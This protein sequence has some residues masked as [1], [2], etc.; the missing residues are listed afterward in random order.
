[1]SEEDEDY[2][3][4]DGSE[5]GGDPSRRR[6]RRRRR[7]RGR[8]PEG[9][10]GGGELFLEDG[11]EVSQPAAAPPPRRERGERPERGGRARGGHE[12]ASVTTPA[13]GR[14]PFR[15]RN[16]RPQRSAPGS[17]GLRRRRLDP[18]QVRALAEGLER[19]PENLLA[20]LFR[21][22]GG[23]PRRL[24]AGERLAGATL[25]ALTQGNR[26]GQLVRQLSDRDRNAL[27]ALLQAGGVAPGDELLRELS[28]SLGGHEREWRRVLQTLAERG[29]VFASSSQEDLFFYV[30]PEVLVEA[31]SAELAGAM[32][33]PTFDHPEVRVIEHH[34]FAPPLDFSITTLATYFSQHG[35]R[36][37]QRHDVFRAHQEALDQF[38]SQL[39]ESQSE[40]FQFH[41]DFLMMH[42]LV[43]LAG[44]H[45]TLDRDVMEAWLQLEPEDQRDLI[46]RALDRRFELGEWVLWAVAEAGE[47]WVAEAPLMALYRRWKRGKDWKERLRAGGLA[48]SRT[49]ERDSFT[50]SPLVQCGLLELGQWGQE[51]F[52]RLTPRAAALLKPSDDDG[53]R[54]FYLTPD[55]QMMAPAGLAPVLLYRMGELGEL[56][57]CDRANTYRITESSIEA[58]IAAGWGRDDILQFLRDNSQFGLPDNVEATLKGWIGYR[59]DVEFHDLLLITVHRA[60]VRRFESSKRVK[61]YVLH[62][63]GPGMYAVDRARRDEIARLL[64]EL[65]F[66]PKADVR[67]YPA[68]EGRDAR[69]GLHKALLEAREAAVERQEAPAF[70]PAALV[71]VP[72]AR[73][74]ASNAEP[75]L[76]PVVSAAEARAILDEAIRRDL[77]VEMVYV[78]RTGQKMAFLVRP[79]RL[80][81]KGDSPV[82]VGLDIG[83]GERRTYVIESIERLRIQGSDHG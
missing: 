65:G 48:A 42:G 69:D 27:G 46:F 26:L 76:P 60:Q 1:M 20:T 71:G 59:G 15:R 44:D 3:E 21:G 41:L 45:I 31:L 19:L 6:R 78:A 23:Q 37:T 32:R 62:R 70:D 61:P 43:R 17:A 68:G 63:F 52:Y 34:P 66:S 79:E 16:S 49:S 39:W 64:G 25:R 80:A 5:S 36:L 30:V 9:G 11:D 82:L 57:S 8:R 7:G 53:F 73:V 10:E 35:V 74:A 13:G 24:P 51:K 77:A 72:G 47:A 28:L 81:F 22:L 75:D 18:A 29:L 2:A 55:F 33:L 50:F 83:D 40:L 4:S 67:G 58:A 38:F 56:T 54:Q 14:N 12:D